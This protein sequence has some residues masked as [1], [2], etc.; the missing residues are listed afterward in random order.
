MVLCTNKRQ[1]ENN[2]VACTCIVIVSASFIRKRG[3]GVI[4]CLI[5]EKM[6]LRENLLAL[7][8]AYI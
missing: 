7:P 3:M 2:R 6:Y 1:S 5:P 4:L 8:I